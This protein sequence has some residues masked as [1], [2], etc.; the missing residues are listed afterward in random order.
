MGLMKDRSKTS[1]PGAP[2]LYSPSREL[3]AFRLNAMGDMHSDLG[4]V[5][6]NALEYSMDVKLFQQIDTTVTKR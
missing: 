5:E 4:M 3:S 6:K 1:G 2:F